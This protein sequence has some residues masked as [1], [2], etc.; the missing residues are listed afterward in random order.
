VIVLIFQSAEK[1]DTTPI[2]INIF[3]ARR[4]R[5]AGVFSLFT[6]PVFSG[7]DALAWVRRASSKLRNAMIWLTV[8]KSR[9]HYPS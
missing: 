6:V 4:A 1:E 9:L 5:R 7:A 3:R 2:A 8:I